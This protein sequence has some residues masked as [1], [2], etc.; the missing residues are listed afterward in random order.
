MARVHWTDE[1]LDTAF[2]ALRADIGGL[3]VELHADMGS[4]RSELHADMGSL[5]REI[6]SEFAE[7]RRQLFASAV[8][9]IVALVGVI[10]ALLIAG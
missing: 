1:R 10:G 5:R 2:R 4:L 9:I 7:L 3:R 8:A 6:H